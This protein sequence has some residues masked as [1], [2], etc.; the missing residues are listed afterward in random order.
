MIGGDIVPRVNINISEDLK[1]YFEKKSKE[2]GASQSALMA[3]YLSEYVDQKKAMSSVDEFIQLVK[4]N[5]QML[6]DTQA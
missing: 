2:T 4:K 1:E 6:N 5:P 3:L